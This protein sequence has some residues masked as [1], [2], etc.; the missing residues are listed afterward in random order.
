MTVRSEFDERIRS[1]SLCCTICSH[2]HIFCLNEYL[3]R[4]VSTKK[5]IQLLKFSMN[6]IHVAFI[7]KKLIILI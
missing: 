7:I 1:Q 4:K 2:F 3:Q 5:G 6:K